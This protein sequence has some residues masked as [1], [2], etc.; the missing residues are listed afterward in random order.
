MANTNPSQPQSYV[1][2]PQGEVEAIGAHC[3]LEYCHVLD[4][5]PFKCQSC[6]GTFCLDHRSEYAH[7]CI[8]EGAWARARTEQART[9]SVPSKPSLYTHDQQCYD[10]SCKTLINT[11]RM[12]ANQCSSCNRS[13]CLKHRMPEDHDCKNV[14]RRGATAPSARQQ[15]MSALSK[16]KLWAENK[17]NEDAKRRSTPKKSGG[18][19]GLGKNSS[20]AASAQSELNML[21]RTAKGEASVPQEKR[22]YLHVEASADT[23]KAKFPTGKFFYNKEWTVGRV[24]DMAAKSLQVQNVNNRGGGEE[25]KLRVFHVEGGRLLK[26]AEKIG[27]S[28]TTGNMIV[29]L[30][31]VGDGEP[32][33]I[34]L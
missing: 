25:E 14:P 34:D 31:G 24:L 13:Y 29:L 33:L 6:K 2:M 28:C 23:T 20:A 1:E 3:Q 21:K 12:P 9:S 30:R 8:N 18:F 22:I 16:L 5:L 10:K 27:E 4:F 19:L 11:P 32:D 26:F 15:T 17:R 7:K